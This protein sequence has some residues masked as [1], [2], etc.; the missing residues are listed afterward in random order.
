MGVLRDTLGMLR[1]ALKLFEYFR[2][3]SGT[4]YVVG[5][6]QKKKTKKKKV[7]MMLV[8]KMVRVVFVIHIQPPPDKLPTQPDVIE[9]DGRFGKN[10]GRF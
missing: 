10:A 8:V 2:G 1:D 7:M 3:R 4:G 6:R 9:K 5:R